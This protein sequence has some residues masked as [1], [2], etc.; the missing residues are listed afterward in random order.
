MY[1]KRKFDAFVSYNHDF[2]ISRIAH[3]IVHKLEHYHAPR[4]SGLSRKKLHLC[5]DD[6]VF[7]AGEIL[8]EQIY[9]ALANSEYL[10]YLAS[11]ETAKSAYCLDEVRAFKKLHNG[12]LNNIIVLLV[13]GTPET[14]FP[15]ELLYEGCDIIGEP[16]SP[17]R[18]KKELH[19]L[20]LRGNSRSKIIN[21]LTTVKKFNNELTMIAAPLLNC[22]LETLKQREQQYIK[23]KNN[24]KRLIVSIIAILAFCISYTFW[25]NRSTDYLMQA[26]TAQDNGNDSLALFYY[27]K[28]LSI[29]PLSK[30]ARINAQLLLQNNIWPVF[31]KEDR[32]AC[33]MGDYIYLQDPSIDTEDVPALVKNFVHTTTSGNYILW[34]G[35]DN[36]Y[37][38]TDKNGSLLETF[39][40]IGQCIYYSDVVTDVWCFSSGQEKKVTLYWPEVGQMETLKWDDPILGVWTAF[41]SAALKPGTYAV[42]NENFLMIFQLENGVYT[43]LHSI[44]LTELFHPSESV[45]DEI[46]DAVNT[47][48]YELSLWTSPDQSLFAVTAE[49]WSSINGISDCWCSVAL[50]GSDTFNPI[51]TIEN[52]D[53]LI[54]DIVFQMDSQK[55]ALIYNNEG[56]VIDNRGYSVVYDCSGN[57]I[58]ST[59]GTCEIIPTKGYFCGNT[60]LLCNVGTV[61]FL[62]A[63]TGNQLCEP[64]KLNISNAALVNDE[65]IALEVFDQVRYYQLFQYSSA[66]SLE[67]PNEYNEISLQQENQMIYE[68]DNGLQVVL[69]ETLDGIQLTD[70]TGSILDRYIIGQ[71]EEKIVLSLE[72]GKNSQTVF[73][74]DSNRDLHCIPVDYNLRQ[75][76]S[77]EKIFVRAGILDFSPGKDGVVYLDSYYPGYYFSNASSLLYT[78]NE[79][80]LFFH[81]P[82]INYVGWR[83]NPNII[84]TFAKL[85]SGESGYAI[86]ASIKEEQ[87]HLQFFDMKNG[88]FL[89]DTSVSIT[90]DLIITISDDNIL[91]IHANGEWNSWWLDDR[92]YTDRSAIRQLINLSGYSS[93]DSDETIVYSDEWGGWSDSLMWKGIPFP[94]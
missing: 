78:T 76:A 88:D 68:I 28:T 37:Y 46:R 30:K 72:Y 55:L 26:Q 4:I 42:I 59:D 9:E 12:K 81:D 63:E 73:V 57:Q 67:N 25:L 19:W 36:L 69:S 21:F 77:N 13:N 32:D 56:T 27:G 29:N 2:F 10:I 54:H 34:A 93:S 5:I 74:L 79:N 94:M 82:A 80:F 39:S 14:V 66:S 40:D 44:D 33:I 70:E 47:A 51:T 91:Y 85:L 45:S 71:D 62:D 20:D 92:F 16:P 48:S 24:I 58:F 60:F 18:A 22:D 11:E 41:S 53:C 75:F 86:I 43:K 38:V 17:D 61:Y 49:Y 31:V 87:V 3:Y 64:L 8:T 90:E 84:G 50:F 89:A 1:E 35:E 65:Q 23:K 83:A 15:P 52:Q 6:Q 7:A